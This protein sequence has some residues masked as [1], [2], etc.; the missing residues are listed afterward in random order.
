MGLQKGDFFLS[1]KIMC[2][3]AFQDLLKYYVSFGWHF[4][5]FN[6]KNGEATEEIGTIMKC[7]ETPFERERGARGGCEN[8]MELSMCDGPIE[9]VE[10]I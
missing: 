5:F 1:R 10:Y 6:D 3:E 9:I 7:G 4:E 8:P 2:E